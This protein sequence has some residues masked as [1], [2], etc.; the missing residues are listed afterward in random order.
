M[1]AEINWR[2][3]IYRGV[4]SDELD[5][6]AAQNWQK[7]NRAGKVKFVRHC[8]A[9]ANTKGGYVVVGVGED[10]AG[11]P[12]LFTGLTPEEAQSFDPTAVGT[13]INRYTDPQIDFSLERPVV[14]GKRYAVFVIRRFSS[15]PH[16]CIAG[17]EH[18]LLQGVFYIRTADASSRPAYR[19]SEIHGI[20][21]RAMR[22]QREALGRMIRGLL[23]ESHTAPSGEGQSHFAEE[24]A[25]SRL[26]FQ[27]RRKS[28]PGDFVLELTFTPG[29]YVSER[30][31]LS[32]LRHQ[33]EDAYD[34]R[35]SS[36]FLQLSE[37]EDAYFTNVSLRFASQDHVWQ[38]YQ[39]GLF[40]YIA[41]FPLNDHEISYS[42]LRDFLA[43]AVQYAA[44]L[45]AGLGFDEETFLISLSLNHVENALLKLEG[46]EK[47]KF[48]C[49][50]P[51]I[52]VNLNRTAADLASGYVFHAAELLRS[53]C[54]R[55]NLPES[56]HRQVIRAME[57]H[58][59]P[60][61]R[62]R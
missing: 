20:I 33:A 40:H 24:L 36:R 25:H 46:A 42:F 43:E 32:E 37:L 9:M 56:H 10:D 27:K 31:S 4:E 58:L 1:G 44:E 2:D 23:Y 49:R 5:Y 38:L 51:E 8:L 59:N 21:Q 26:F 52:T 55:F 61:D 7:L 39:S 60:A 13:F 19:S 34:L 6:K 30:F 41:S 18:E 50:I 48:L 15:L 12:A 53:V 3:I 35:P 11:Q 16:V 14:D 45:Y 22:N 62:K 57:E 54:D 17:Y 47:E 28:K 29:I